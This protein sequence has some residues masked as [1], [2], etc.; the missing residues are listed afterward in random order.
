[1][2][3][4]SIVKGDVSSAVVERA[5]DVGEV[6]I[7]I[8]TSGLDCKAS[9]ICTC[10]VAIAEKVV[11][12]QFDANASKPMNLLEI[13][14]SDKILKVFHQALFDLSFMLQH[15]GVMAA[16]VTCTKIASKV[17]SVN[18][19][20]ESHSLKDVLRRYLGV[21]INKGQRM[22]DWSVDS[23]TSDQLRYAAN[24]V[25]YLVALHHHLEELC[26]SQGVISAL[27]AAGDYLPIRVWC[28][29]HEIGDVFVY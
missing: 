12:I 7:D 1:V 22:S 23:L 16:N 9:R 8:E 15:W 25:R 2:N 14:S 3:K 6:A 29:V 26:K 17:L 27:R 18:G 5:Y 21:D 24:D 11:I 13:V 28:E 10:Q 19:D 4:L 20:R